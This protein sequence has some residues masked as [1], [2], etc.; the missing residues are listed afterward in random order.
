MANPVWVGN[1]F[2][3]RRNSTW[4]D[5]PELGWKMYDHHVMFGAYFFYSLDKVEHSREVY[6]YVNILSEIGGLSEILVLLFGAT[7]IVFNEKLMTAKYIRI[8]YFKKFKSS[9]EVKLDKKMR[10]KLDKITFSL[11]DKLSDFKME[12]LCCAK[13]KLKLLNRNEKLY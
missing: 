9:K 3:S 2:I 13:K 4:I 12:L 1:K 10:P 6:T 7:A 11:L 8:L 5:Q